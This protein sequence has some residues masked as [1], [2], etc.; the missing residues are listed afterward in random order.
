MSR[1]EFK[2]L[3]TLLIIIGVIIVILC[4]CECFQCNCRLSCRRKNRINVRPPL[5]VQATP[6]DT[7][8]TEIIVI[9]EQ[10]SSQEMVRGDINTVDAL[11]IHINE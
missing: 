1:N 2:S 9:G 3:F 8:N 6:L 10:L 7:M 11:L 4:Q 5:L